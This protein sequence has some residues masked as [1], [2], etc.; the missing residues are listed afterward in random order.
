MFVVLLG[1][2]VGLGGVV[3]RRRGALYRDSIVLWFFYFMI[4]SRG[5]GSSC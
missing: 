3:G 4:L 2:R 1:G 5:F